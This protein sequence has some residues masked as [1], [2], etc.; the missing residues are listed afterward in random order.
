V[1]RLSEARGLPTHELA[2]LID[3]IPESNAAIARELGRSRTFVSRLR[4]AW[5]G[6]CP[7][8]R[9]AWQEGAIAF[10]VVKLIAPM[11]GPEQSRA[12]T[13]YIKAT[14]GRTRAAKA[15]ARA[16]LEK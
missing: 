5:R 4:S 14:K 16:V 12:L 15:P 6:A 11:S 7:S 1:I 13:K 3:S 9:A 2:K 8:L 10:D